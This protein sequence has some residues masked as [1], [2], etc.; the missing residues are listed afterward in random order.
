M[1]RNIEI[2]IVKG[3]A[4][5]LMVV[6]HAAI[7]DNFIYLFHMS[8]FFMA[9]GFFYKEK[10]S[11]DFSSVKNYV[12][13]K[14]KSLWLP[15]ALWTA[16]FSLLRNFFID[17]NVYTNNPL[18]YEY[19][20]EGFAYVTEY[21]TWKEILINIVKGC[22]LPGNVQMGGALWFLATLLQISVAYCVMEFVLRKFV[23]K[24]HL[25]KAQF[26]VSAVLLLIGYVLCI[27]DVYIFGIES[28]F[29]CYCLYYIGI[30]LGRATEKLADR[31]IWI[32]VAVFI[33]CFAVLSVL[34]QFGS[35]SLGGNKYN[36]PLFMLVASLAGWFLLYEVAVIIKRNSMI[37]RVL[38]YLGKNTLPIVVLHF[39][40]FKI[41]S[42]I[43]VLLQGDYLIGISAFPILYTGIWW[44]ILYSVVGIVVPLVLNEVWLK[45]KRRISY[46]KN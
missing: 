46:G 23:N 7:N 28:F 45:L 25:L 13:K 16:I 30:L 24:K 34:N 26:A 9:A 15:Y 4:I 5:I 33:L 32:S 8:V 10:V 36:N 43:G 22:I 11:E 29:S 2:D 17:I 3:I 20:D 44:C 31:K 19:V 1:K 40:A 38:A 27:N 37:S 41:V 14:F 6:G 39:L 18:V 21:W 12:I 35:I 42:F